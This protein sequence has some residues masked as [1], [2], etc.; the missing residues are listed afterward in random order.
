[1]AVLKQV[2][3]A[4]VL[5][6]RAW[7]CGAAL[8]AYYSFNDGTATESIDSSLDGTVTG[9][10]TTTGPSGSGALSLDGVDDYVEFPTALT[11]N[12]GSS[13]ARTICLFAKIDSFTYGGTGDVGALFEYG[14]STTLGNYALRPMGTTGTIRVHTS[15]LVLRDH[16]WHS[17]HTELA[18]NAWHIVIVGPNVDKRHGRG[19]VRV[20]RRRLAPL[21]PDLRRNGLD[22][23][24]RRIGRSHGD[25]CSEHG[26]GSRFPLGQMAHWLLLGL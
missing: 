11:A 21:L 24:L 9:A 23:I 16:S 26:L 6:L 10:G 1:M 19:A 2:M 13:S 7:P 14:S 20:G 17:R 8:L 25:R 4:L 3:L 22:P 5:L 18:G 15:V 12:I